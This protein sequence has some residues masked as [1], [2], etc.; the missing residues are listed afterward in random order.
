MTKTSVICEAHE[1]I[2]CVLNKETFLWGILV[3]ELWFN[4]LQIK[5]LC[6]P[7]TGENKKLY[8]CLPRWQQTKLDA[9][10]PNKML[11]SI[12]SHSCQDRAAF[13]FPL[14][15]FQAFSLSECEEGMYLVQTKW[16]LSW[17]VKTYFDTECY[18]L[19]GRR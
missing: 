15:A 16:Y 3:F 18:G 2:L 5:C 11:L 9:N 7:K 10:V 14:W 13:V 6:I 17:K 12:H 19:D 4:S 8:D 1:K